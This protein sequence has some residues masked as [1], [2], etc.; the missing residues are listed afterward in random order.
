VLFGKNASDITVYPNT[1]T[2]GHIIHLY[3]VN[4]PAGR[5]M[6]KLFN[7]AGQLIAMRKL[8]HA[9]ASATEPFKLKQSLVQRAYQLEVKE[10]AG[11]KKTIGIAVL[12]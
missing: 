3:F 5:Y 2:E 10:P 6:I 8:N 1:I 12:N 9:S 7:S 4:Q 11:A